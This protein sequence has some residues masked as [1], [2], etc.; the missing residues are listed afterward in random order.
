[1]VLHWGRNGAAGRRGGGESAAN[2]INDSGQIAGWS[3]TAF[4]GEDAVLWSSTGVGT[5]LAGILGSDWT[6]TAANAINDQG[7]IVAPALTWALK[8]V[9][10]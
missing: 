3:M 6:F 1:M 5:N 4:G 9:F 2:F 7:D 10:S 8:R